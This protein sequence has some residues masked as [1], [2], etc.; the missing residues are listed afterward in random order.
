MKFFPKS[1][2]HDHLDRHLLKVFKFCL[3]SLLSADSTVKLASGT[4]LS[5]CLSQMRQ[6][7]H[8]QLSA[9]EHLGSLS[10]P[11]KIHSAWLLKKRSK[12]PLCLQYT[13]KKKKKIIPGKKNPVLFSPLDVTFGSYISIYAGNNKKRPSVLDAL[14]GTTSLKLILSHHTSAC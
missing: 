14:P 13:E 2:R 10:C 8:I 5:I 11:G 12:H 6:G 3:Q 1:T 4:Q 9:N 7:M